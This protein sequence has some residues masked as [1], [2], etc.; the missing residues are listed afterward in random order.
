[1]A[2]QGEAATPARPAAPAVRKYV[3]QLSA[4]NTREDA[5][6]ALRAAQAKYSDLLSGRHTLVKEKKAA[7]HTVYAAQVGPLSSKEEAVELCQRLKSAGASC[8]VQ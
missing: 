8:F 3:V 6:A 5:Q 2:P 4:S 7:D 1:L